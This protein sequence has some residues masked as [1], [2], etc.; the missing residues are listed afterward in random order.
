M[1]GVL[2]SM[3][4]ILHHSIYFF[5]LA[6]TLCRMV[7][8]CWSPSLIHSL[9]TVFPLDVSSS[10]RCWGCKSI[11]FS[12]LLNDLIPY[13]NIFY[14]SFFICFRKRFL[15]DNAIKFRISS[16]SEIANSVNL[17]K[18]MAYF[19]N[20]LCEIMDNINHCYAIQV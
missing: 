5:F 9:C 16:S 3:Q 12:Y 11:F 15:I 18:R 7:P 2:Y 6:Q 10:I 19:H 8:K 14:L 13:F 4:E 1:Y 17:V 20:N